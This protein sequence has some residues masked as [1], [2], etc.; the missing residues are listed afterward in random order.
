MSS[1]REPDPDNAGGGMRARNFNEP[2]PP[3]EEVFLHAIIFAAGSITNH[4]SLRVERQPEDII[5]AADGGAKHCLAMQIAPDVVIGDFD[6]LSETEIQRLKN[7]GARL[8]RYP[9]R[10]DFTDLELA[11]Q[12]A[13]QLNAT[14]I[15]VYGALGLRWDQTLANMLLLASPDL[16]CASIRLIDDAQEIFLI[17]AKTKQEIYGKP[18]DIVSLIPI[19]GDAIGI[20]STNLEYPLN[21]DSLSFGKARGVS[22]VLLQNPAT[23]YLEKGD[24]ICTVIHQSEQGE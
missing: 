4:R 22:N 1:T 17:R 13:C 23:I 12:Y 7:A 24:L 15:L 21:G 11:L 19:G 18:G 5:I 16:N 6:S 20:T 3:Q 2:S 14:D 8:I 10:K 9:T